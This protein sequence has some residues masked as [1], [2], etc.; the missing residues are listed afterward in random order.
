MAAIDDKISELRAQGK[1]EST[2]KSLAKLVNAKKSGVTQA[3]GRSGLSDPANSGGSTGSP[4]SSGMGGADSTIQRAIEMNQ[5]AVRPA[6]ESISAGIPETQ[7]QFSQQRDQLNAEKQPLV[8]RYNN[9][10]SSLKGNQTTAENRQTVATRNEQGRRGITGGGVYDQQ[11]VDALNPITSEYTGMIKDTGLQQES[12]LRNLVNQVS[13]SYTQE[14]S[15]TRAIRNALAQLQAGAGQAG[16]SQGIQQGQ[17]NTAQSNNMNQFNTQQDMVRRLF[18][19]V[20]LP[21]S[22]ANI[23]NINSTIANRGTESSG[24]GLADF[25]A[26]FGGGKGESGKGGVPDYFTPLN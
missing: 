10:I 24:L 12:D 18:N 9:L 17:F 11:L 7:A 26:A 3:Y 13:N 2:S 21:E 15:A 22:K 20:Q 8:D 25:L 16:I 4:G 14:T 23:A 1:S 5:Q 6:V 19:E